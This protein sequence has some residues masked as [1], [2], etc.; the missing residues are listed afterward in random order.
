MPEVKIGVGANVGN[1]DQAISKITQSM[2]KL[3][4]AV[5]ANQKLK[6]EPTDVKAMARDLDLINK[7]FKQTLALSAQIRNALKSS[8][9]NGL[10]LSQ[11]DW[12]K[13][14]TDP[15]AAQRMRD[16]AFMHS[17]RGTSLDPTLFNDVDD[18][19]NAVSAAKADAQAEKARSREEAADARAKTRAEKDEAKKSAREDA[20]ARK[21][22]EKDPSR[23]GGFGRG[24]KKYAS[25]MA[26]RTA[27]AFGGGIGGPTGGIL[28]EGLQGAGS[29]MEAGAMLGGLG[30]LAMGLLGGSAIAIAGTAGKAIS[31]GVDQAKDRNLDLDTLKR[32][33]GDLGVSFDGL[34]D[35]SWKAA[36]GLGVANGEFVKLEQL[37]NASSGGAYRTPDEL[38]SNTRE[39]VD[40]ARAYGMQPGQGVGFMSGMQRLDSR[41]NNKELATALA[42]AITNAQGKATAS[43]VMQAMQGFAAAQNRFNSGSVDLNR[44][45]NAYS[46]LL[47]G[48]GM[49]ADHAS[50]ILGQ[51]NSAMQQMGGTEASKNFTM[52]AFGSL[53]P[54]RSA[55]RAEGGLFGNGLENR[56]ISGYMS[57]HGVTDWDSQGKGP[58]ETN[59]SVIRG[60]F[61]KAYAGRSEYGAE[62]ELDAEKNYFGLKSYADTSA[63]MNMSDSDHNGIDMMLKNAGVSLKDVREGGIQTIAGVTKAADFNELDGL[64]RNGPDAI[65]NRSDMSD[66]D[67]SALD[68]AEKGGDFQ[69][70]QN[71]LVRVLAGKGQEDDAGSTQRSIDANIA[72]MKTMVGERLIPY[73]QAIMQGILAFAN[74][75]P[76]VHVQNPE[77]DGGDMFV[78]PSSSA[79]NPNTKTGHGVIGGGAG[80]A[81]S[82]APG[83]STVGGNGSAKYIRP[84]TTDTSGDD[85]AGFANGV[86]GAAIGGAYEVNDSVIGG[87]NQ[88]SGMGVDKDHSAAIMASA[89]R[90]SSMNPAAGSVGSYGLFQFDKT[91]AADFQKV[92]G[93]S[94]YGSSASEQIDYMVRSMKKGGEEAGPGAAFWA[95]D[96][97]DAARV[98]SDKVERPKEKGKEGD[99]RSGIASELMRSNVGAQP[100][101][102]HASDKKSGGAI[103]VAPKR[104]PLSGETVGA[105]IELPPNK[106]PEK[107]P[108]KFRAR[109]AAPAEGASSASAGS[110]SRDT[111]A[112][113]GDIVINLSQNVTTP[114]GQTKTKTLSAKVAKPSASGLQT[115]TNIQLPG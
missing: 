86:Y 96:G 46:T 45:G 14:S 94:L 7:Q 64:Y 55:M 27:G 62:M 69:K 16:R 72:D 83:G 1:V 108:E 50:S 51:A 99:I 3:G 52:Q 34:S 105:I 113:N 81:A 38:A 63:L 39:G 28:Q 103:E 77:A 18:E 76:G 12:S 104:V 21:T 106:A 32:S 89:I 25:G 66:S 61:D 91:R 15:R 110:V 85:F 30:G 10:H 93:K 60:A 4:S 97:K 40:L 35:A 107:I 49:T 67:K 23:P 53:D 24:I 41:Q 31:E 6:F 26:G 98:F 54:I 33:M 43:E 56:A 95:S 42:E 79:M 101:K 100:T 82:P 112:P 65:R 78:G 44:F 29:G 115:A 74:K 75:I 5:A 8:G 2:N 19:G 57:Q 80:S 20:A 58:H 70:F 22:A 87:M 111:R 36:Q 17:V 109:A 68:R 84:G 102:V 47:N 9:Q 71:E 48:D 114:G 73:T 90:E 11:V 59:F 88:L 13:T 92:M 37:A